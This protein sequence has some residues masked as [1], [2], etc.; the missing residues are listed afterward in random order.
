MPSNWIGREMRDLD[1][2]GFHLFGVHPRRLG[3]L[4]WRRF[5][6][7][8]GP[9]KICFPREAAVRRDQFRVVIPRV[10]EQGAAPGGFSA[11]GIPV[12]GEFESWGKL[13]V[14]LL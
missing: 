11:A 9:E 1:Q 3:V 7:D 12:L 13:G 4:Q 8:W 14:Y 10:V 6:D 2:T 5:G